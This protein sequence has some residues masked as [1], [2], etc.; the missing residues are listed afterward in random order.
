MIKLALLCLLLWP[1]ISLAAEVRP[2]ANLIANGDFEVGAQTPDH[3]KAS[4]WDG[5]PTIA[6]PADGGRMGRGLAITGKGEEDTV[7]VTQTVKL[8]HPGVPHTLRGHWKGV[9][10]QGAARVV[11]RYLD[12]GGQK[13]TDAPP[14]SKTGTFDW[15][16]FLV[17]LLPPD[18]TAA[19]TIYLELWK[20]SGQAVYDDIA[21][22]REPFF[23]TIA[24]SPQPHAVPADIKCDR[25]NAQRAATI[26]AP[27]GSL[28]IARAD[29]AKLWS[30]DVPA[31]GSTELVLDFEGLPDGEYALLIGDSKLASLHLSRDLLTAVDALPKG[32]FVWRAL[33]NH[34][35]GTHKSPEDVRDMVQAAKEMRFTT[36]LFAA[37]PPNGK[38]YYHSDIGERA[39]GY[40]DWDVLQVVSDE[41][42]K[43]GLQCLVQFCTFIEGS[44]KN[45]TRFIRE[46]PDLVEIDQGEN[47]DYKTHR[48]VFGCPDRPEVRAYELS[49]I[50]EICTNYPV[51][52]ISFDYIRYKNDRQCDC[53][54]SRQK[55]SEFV[56][57]HPELPPARAAARF[58][59]LA[60][61][62]FTQEVRKLLDGIRPGLILHAYTHPVWA[63]EFP[64]DY[65]SQR[66]SAHGKD[67]A[68]GGEWPL[69]RVYRAS[70]H[71]VEIAQ[72]H[73]PNCL[74]APMADTAYLKWAKSPERFRREIR[75]IAH[76]GAP[77][78]MVY[79]WST[80]KHKPEL[81]QCIKEEF[82]ESP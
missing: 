4:V 16:P 13:I 74:A 54:F 32:K 30:H 11:C 25:L 75:L 29:G 20:G 72:Q 53:P 78:I 59:E 66:A 28:V 12:E 49:L 8:P 23:L 14:I 63:N 40:E 52:G 58:N 42:H 31:K 77:A 36:I 64:L 24:H 80:L 10:L 56:Q 15:E 60:I 33:N 73:H 47:S 2:A 41:C 43:A 79:P 57:A 19:V 18:G 48:T 81:R 7:V 69:E 65:H 44:G 6:F 45:P 35:P 67:P 61:I 17:E 68:R 1:L 76:A 50:K 34:G 51:D 71:L 46:H 26:G 21:L 62:S 70:R 37:K 22:Y 27:G 5:E 82:S 3:W 9:D 38:L 39:P 55:R